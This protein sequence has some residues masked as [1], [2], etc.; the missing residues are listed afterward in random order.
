VQTLVRGLRDV[1]NNLP[2][3]PHTWFQIASC[4]KVVFYS[5][6]SRFQ[7]HILFG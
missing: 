2:V 7:H 1:S 3:N 4:S 6:F 5:L